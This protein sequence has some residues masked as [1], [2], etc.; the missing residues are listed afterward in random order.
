MPDRQLR[1]L[2]RTVVTSGVAY[3]LWSYVSTLRPTTTRASHTCQDPG[4]RAG[5]RGKK[6]KGGGGDGEGEDSKVFFD[7]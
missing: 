2:A 3:A 6:G 1:S 5:A 7:H 4:P